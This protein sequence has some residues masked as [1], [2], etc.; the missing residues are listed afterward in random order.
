MKPPVVQINSLVRISIGCDEYFFLT[1]LCH[2]RRR[3]LDISTVVVAMIRRFLL[4]VTHVCVDELQEPLPS[5]SGTGT[6]KS[7]S[8]FHSPSKFPLKVG[9]SMLKRGTSVSTEQSLCESLC[10]T[11]RAAH[12]FAPTCPSRPRLGNMNLIPD[13]EALR[14]SAQSLLQLAISITSVLLLVL[15]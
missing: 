15:P 9:W 4:R 5:Q 3:P 2:R 6:V 8:S 14:A 10:E 1:V 7:F 11:D 12:Q 13:R